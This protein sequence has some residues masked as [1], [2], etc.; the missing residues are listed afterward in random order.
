MF[1]TTTGVIQGVIIE[2]YLAI[3]TAQVVY[4][5]NFIQDLFASLRDIMGGH[6]GS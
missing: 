1:V 2:S 5:S 6:T 4:G 3:V